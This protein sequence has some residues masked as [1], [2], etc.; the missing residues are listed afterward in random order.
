MRSLT[1]EM[2]AALDAPTVRPVILFEGLFNSGILRLHT[3]VGTV[4]LDGSPFTGAGLLMSVSPIKST[5]DVRAAGAQVT[6]S[7][8][9]DA[10]IALALAE[11]RRGYYGIIR[12]GCL[13]DT[14]SELI[15][16]PFI[17][18]RGKCDTIEIE[19]S[20]DGPTFTI[21]YE[22]E[23]IDLER[24][25]ETRYT[26]PEQLLQTNGT[27]SFFEYIAGMQDKTLRWGTK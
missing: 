21:N 12:F 25:R 17:F 26:H 22:N 2:I 24:P 4:V 11:F 18:F 9:K 1:P 5:T 20:A 3:A 10:S 19:D 15:P 7:A 27:D 23:L 14:L 13:D 8:V 16:D 6:L